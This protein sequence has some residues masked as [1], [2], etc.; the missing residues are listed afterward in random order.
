MFWKNDEPFLEIP[1]PESEDRP[2]IVYHPAAG[3]NYLS[4]WSILVE[5]QKPFVLVC[6][7]IGPH[8]PDDWPFTRDF[9]NSEYFVRMY[10]PLIGGRAYRNPDLDF[11]N[12]LIHRAIDVNE[13][14]QD[15]PL[16]DILYVDWLDPFINQGDEKTSANVFSKLAKYVTNGGIIILDKKHE[17][18]IPEWFDF[19]HKEVQINDNLSIQHLGLGDWPIPHVSIEGTRPVM[20][21][22]F[23]VNNNQK[24]SDPNDFLSKLNFERRLEIKDLQRIRNNPPDRF[25]G[26]PDKDDW[27]E[28]YLEHLDLPKYF[29]KP[30][31]PF[32]Q[33]Y[34]W[35]KSDYSK[36]IEELI[37]KPCQLRPTSRKERN[38][39]INGLEITFVHGDIYDHLDWLKSLDASIL[40]RKNLFEKCEKKMYATMSKSPRIQRDFHKPLI[41]KLR[42]SGPEAT[43]DLTLKLL[44]LAETEIAATIAHGDGTIFQ[45]ENQISNWKNHVKKLIIFHLDE[46]DY[47]S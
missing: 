22:I 14:I 26:F 29:N 5:N 8:Y 9:T 12:M 34:V 31:Y 23:R 44:D 6:D 28:R 20:A 11:E 40:L 36:W 47:S 7:D 15:M 16:V 38:I 18:V 43:E 30:Q 39:E 4:S 3:I 1:I 10:N 19:N 25:P 32:P 45:L 21:E 27:M 33:D 24:D 46:E 42:W 13:G 35:K 37:S 2:L 41:P 17:D